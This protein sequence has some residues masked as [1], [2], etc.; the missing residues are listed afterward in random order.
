MEEGAEGRVGA[1]SAHLVL[2][3]TTPFFFRSEEGG[4]RG[5]FPRPFSGP[6]PRCFGLSLCG[7]ALALALR[8]PTSAALSLPPMSLLPADATSSFFLPLPFLRSPPPSFSLRFLALSPLAAGSARL[9]AR[10]VA[11]A[12]VSGLDRELGRGRPDARLAFEPATTAGPSIVNDVPGAPG[13][14]IRQTWSVSPAR[15]TV[16]A[17]R[18]GA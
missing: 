11:T 8:G 12:A 2:E 17:Q 1:G 10:G 16:A 7:P 14:R 4:D 9:D 15:C 6:P 18:A 3:L 13:A 5:D